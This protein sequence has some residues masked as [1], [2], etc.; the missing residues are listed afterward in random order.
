MQAAAYKM[1]ASERAIRMVY[2]PFFCKL[3]C[4]ST[5]T[6]TNTNLTVCS[7]KQP[8]LV[9][10]SQLDTCSYG[11]FFTMTEPVTSWMSLYLA[12]TVAVIDKSSILSILDIVHNCICVLTCVPLT[13]EHPVTCYGT[14]SWWCHRS[15]SK[16]VVVCN[17]ICAHC[18]GLW[19][20]AVY[21]GCWSLFDNSERTV[22]Y[23]YMRSDPQTMPFHN[24][25]MKTCCGSQYL[26]ALRHSVSG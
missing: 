14:T 9:K 17:V 18:V 1:R 15:M 8:Y 22:I 21:G 11:L 2:P 23:R 13:R 7:F 19:S 25:S 10:P 16:Q 4:S 20:G 5:P 12:L 24:F 6:N 3:R 26:T